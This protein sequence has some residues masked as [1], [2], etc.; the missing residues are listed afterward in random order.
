VV[1]GL[2]AYDVCFWGFEKKDK[3]LEKMKFDGQIPQV[4]DGSGSAVEVQIG[5]VLQLGGNIVCGHERVTESQTF[6][7]FVMYTEG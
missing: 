4:N 3:A 6:V 2:S 7:W 5:V 1:Q